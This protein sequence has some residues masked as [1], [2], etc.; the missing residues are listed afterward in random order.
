MQRLHVAS[1]LLLGG[2]EQ[3]DALRYDGKIT[4]HRLKPLFRG[5]GSFFRSVERSVSLSIRPCPIS[6]PS[7]P[8]LLIKLFDFLGRQPGHSAAS[9]KV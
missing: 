3:L 1:H 8:R 5:N 2:G 9:G 6:G 7:F 4:R